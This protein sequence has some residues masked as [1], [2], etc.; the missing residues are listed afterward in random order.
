MSQPTI[1]FG[2]N[3]V[4]NVVS[5]KTRTIMTEILNHAGLGS[6]LITS[7]SRTPAGQ[8]RVMFNN[9]EKLGIESQKAL[10]AAAGDLVI[11]VYAAAKSA[12]KTADQIKA[13]MEAKI[14][15]IGP[16]KVSRHCADPSRLNVVDVAPSSIGNK[17]AFENAVETALADGSVSR[18]ITPRN[19]DP[20]YHIEVPQK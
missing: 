14:I 9:L 7:T 17:Q 18:F 6:C 3:A 2:A 8:A 13:L 5:E 16:E 4:Q 11:D 19:G 15:A 10:Y 20:A 1:N 12:K